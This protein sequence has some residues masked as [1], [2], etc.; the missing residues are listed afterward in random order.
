MQSTASTLCE[1]SDRF[2][3]FVTA[4][5][6][7]QASVTPPAPRLAVGGRPPKRRAHQVLRQAEEEAG[8]DLCP[9]CYKAPVGTLGKGVAT[10]W[11]PKPPERGVAWQPACTHRLCGW[12]ALVSVSRRAQCPMCRTEV[13][14]LRL[15]F[16]KRFGKSSA[17]L[18]VNDAVAQRHGE[19]E[20]LAD[21]ETLAA[22]QAEEAEEAAQEA[23]QEALTNVRRVEDHLEHEARIREALRAADREAAAFNAVLNDELGA[24]SRCWLVACVL[25]GRVPEDATPE[26][27]RETASVWRA[28]GRPLLHRDVD[29]WELQS[30]GVGR[31]RRQGGAEP[32]LVE[33]LSACGLPRVVEALHG[34]AGWQRETAES[35][36][37]HHLRAHGCMR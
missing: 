12:C 31:R 28:Q 29:G 16:D 5:T 20:V 17:A 4:C 14:A 25:D 22:V 9:V 7:A 19:L 15:D 21:L 37:R 24:A 27:A 2:V 35:Q 8:D 18:G 11:H 13:W 26:T 10:F 36:V 23:L 34:P 3:E 33:L 6:A 1:A 30:V 32:P